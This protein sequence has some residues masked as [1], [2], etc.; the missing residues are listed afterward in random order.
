MRVVI[1]GMGIVSCL[2]TSLDKVS[3][4]LRTG[5]SGIA[6]DPERQQLGFRSPLS[7]V[8]RDYDVRA[9]VNRKQ[10]KTMG[11]PAEFAVG[12]AVEAVRDSGLPLEAL[13]D[14]GA[15]LIVGND[16]CA[17]PVLEACE[18]VRQHKETRQIGSGSIIQ[19][20]N[21]TVSMNLATFFGTRGAAW[22]VSGACAS[23]AHALGQAYL[24][25]QCGMQDV[26]LC[27]GA[28]EINWA[29]MA[30]F[31]ALGAFGRHEEPA[32]ACRPFDKARSGLVPSGGAA[33]LVLERLD[34]AVARGARIHAEVL[35]YAF[36]S[37]GAHL[38]QPSGDGA[39]RAMRDALA[40]ARVSASE[41]EYV[42]AH[43]TGTPAGD[44]VEGKSILEVFGG[45][46]PP[47]S[48]TKSMTGHECWMA[49]ASEVIY[50]A[51][52]MRDGFLAPNINLDE[53]DPELS[54]LDVIARTRPVRPRLVLSNSFGFGGT[55]A[56]LV[57]AAAE[58]RP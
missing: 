13:R 30:S 44:L 6:I 41:V 14:P 29:G 37:D 24:L 9:Y 11:Q 36:S 19:V 50:S 23:G 57:L 27:G 10:A 31:D 46:S 38:T 56:A 49:G 15:G 32:R 51:L 52:M 5:T 26:V 55:N 22:T 42:N 20:M 47:V 16:S 45:R 17:L 40:R 3:Q 39:V 7:G 43:A 28:Q 8:I 33:M 2:G 1:T 34:R 12:A 58:A 25:I 21:S 4:A 48:S 53:L 18:L 54:G 35:G